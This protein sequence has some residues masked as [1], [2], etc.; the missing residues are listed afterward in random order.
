MHRCLSLVMIAALASACYTPTSLAAPKSAPRAMDPH[1]YARPDRVEVTHV[2]LDLQLDFKRKQISGCARLV[3]KRH[4]ARAPLVLDTLGLQIAAVTGADRR[5]RRYTMGDSHPIFG[6]PLS[7]VLEYGDSEVLVTYRTSP[8]AAAL[9]WLDPDQTSSRETQFLYT[10]GQAILTRSWIPLQDTPGV[11]V[12]YEARVSAPDDMTVVMSAAHER[13]PDGREVFRMRQPIPSYLIALACG[14]LEFV[15]ISPRCGVWAEPALIDIAAHEFEDVDAMLERCEQLFGGY[16]WQRYDV[17]VLPPA[18]PFGGME[19]P[20]LTFA[21]PTIL[22]G[23]KSLVALVAHELAHSWSGNLVTNATWSDFWLNEGFTVYLEQRIMEELYGVARANMEI[24][25][26]MQG[27]DEE[28]QTL[29]PGDQVLHIDLTDRNPDDGMT[30]VPYDKGAAF[31][32]RLEQLY[33]RER[34]DAF[35][36]DYFAEHAFQSITTDDFLTYLHAKLLDL[37]PAPALEID[38]EAW[39][40]EPGLP[41]DAPRPQ[42]AAFTL[43]DQALASWQGGTPLAELDTED[44]ITH[45]WL[46]FLGELPADLNPAQMAALDQAFGFTQTR[47]SEILAAWLRQAIRHDYHAA[48]DRL[49]A[50]LETV[51]RRKFLRP[52]YEELVKTPQDKARAVAIY[53]VARPRYHAVSRRTIDKIVGV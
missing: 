17:L 53:Q 36:A 7:V 19:N 18:F 2:D 21:T 28:L 10:Q 26:G 32:R 37:D 38:I 41:D 52:L 23:D 27:L 22:A 43:V 13:G 5:P 44:W 11:R 40:Y 35:L 15:E 29:P 51:G 25:I 9:Q 42:S 3:V 34:F 47:N 31:L 6:T 12:T 4:Q 24:L 8:D 1:S 20:R 46:H 14:A 30:A 33:G 39:V 49:V 50:F 45:Q 16:R 48:D